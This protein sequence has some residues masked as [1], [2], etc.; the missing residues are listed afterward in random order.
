MAST[1]NKAKAKAEVAK[2]EATELPEA[3]V[4]QAVD[5][6]SNPDV[7][8]QAL[9]EMLTADQ[10]QAALLAANPELPKNAIFNGRVQWKHIDTGVEHAGTKIILPDRPI[11]MSLEEGIKALER[12]KKDADTLLNTHEVIDAFPLD[13]A[14]AF[15]K[16]LQ[17]KYG[18]A[19][20]VPTPGFF[21]DEPPQMLTVNI[22][23][24]PEDK[25][26]VPWGGFQI[27]GVENPIHT[28]TTQTAR[29]AAFVIYGEVKKGQ[30]H[31]VKELAEMTREIVKNESIYRGKAIRLRVKGNAA[32]DVNNPPEFVD[33]SGAVAEELVLPEMVEDLINVNVWTL[34]EKTE[35]CR[36]A[37]IPFKRGV[38]LS[39]KYGVGKTMASLITAKKCVENGWTF[40][41]LDRA[42]ALRQT[43]EF[44]RRYEPAVIFAEDIDRAAA[45]RN[46][47][48]NDL[49]NIMDG[50][51]SKGAQIMVVM[52]TNHLDRINQAMLRPGRLD[53]VIPVLP[54]DAEA[55]KKLLRIYGRG[56]IRSGEDLN[57][58]GKELA[59]NIPATIREVMERSKLAAVAAGNDKVTEDNLLTIALG[60][61]QHMALLAEPTTKPLSPE[62]A[63]GQAVARVMADQVGDT[64]ARTTSM[65]MEMLAS[66]FGDRAAQAVTNNNEGGMK[67]KAQIDRLLARSQRLPSASLVPPVANGNGEEHPK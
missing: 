17:R 61:R 45:D 57:R 35:L 51:L 66:H 2:A 48:T 28:S 53:A 63:L 3:T 27:P 42:Q 60:M 40:I 39:G 18:W 32:A 15:V 10:R 54:P 9:V 43:L 26:Q 16:A 30:A 47:S 25:I 22:G 11:P 65:L 34:I 23:P 4:Q 38:L 62:E 44:A 20:S 1:P 41:S 55:V 13:G 5:A 64:T 19:N 7:F 24:E 59:G 29:G 67:F 33:L 6:L 31:I 12:K 21:G 49:L 46:E 52:T 36:Q 14:V 58:I 56:L 8:K 37:K 50:V